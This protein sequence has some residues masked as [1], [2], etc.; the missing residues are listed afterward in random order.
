[1]CFN[2]LQLLQRLNPKYTNLSYLLKLSLHSFSEYINNI[3]YIEI[4]IFPSLRFYFMTSCIRSLG[5]E[6]QSSK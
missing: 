3:D 6:I 5:N 2:I 1:M 4:V